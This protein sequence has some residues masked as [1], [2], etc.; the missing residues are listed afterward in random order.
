MTDSKYTYKIHPAIGFARVGDSLDAYYLEPTTVGGLP[1]EVGVDGQ[2]RPVTEF[3]YAGQ[4]KRQAARF[5]VYRYEDG[6][7]PV[8]VS[9]GNGLESVQWTVHV[10]NKKAAWY[11]F[12]E[13]QGNVMLGLDNTYEAQGVPLRN[14]TV[15]L[16]P[17]ATGDVT[18]RYDKDA[19]QELITDPG[20][21][22]LTAPGPWVQLDAAT[23]P[24]DYDYAV[25][26]P[27][28]LTPYQVTTLGAVKMTDR[29]ELLVLGGHGNAGG[30][31][32][33]DINSFAGAPGWYDD[34]SD[35]PVRAEIQTDDGET[36]TLTAWVVT[37]AP[38]LAPELV[39][40]TSLA[41]TFIDVGVRHMG[42]CPA[43]YRPGPRDAEPGRGYD[44]P[45][46]RQRHHDGHERGHSGRLRG[47]ERDR[48]QSDR[49]HG[50]H[51]HRRPVSVSRDRHEHGHD[52]HGHG[53]GADQQHQ[54]HDGQ[55][56]PY[57]W[58][59]DYVA[60]LERDILPIFRAMKE[61]RWV[62][63]VDAM[64]SVATPPF[65][66]SDLSDANRENRR[67]VFRTFRQPQKGQQ[68][69]ELDSQHQVL[70][71]DNGLPL[72][73]LNSGDNSI[74]NNVIEKFMAVTP[75]QYWLLHQWAE[76]MCVSR[77]D[78]PE[79][80]QDWLPWA[81]PLDIA[82]AGNAVGEPMAPGIEV[83]WTM[84]NPDVLTPGDPFRIKHQVAD[85]S[86]W[87][88]DPFRDETLEGDGCQPGDLTKRMAIPWQADFF[89]CSEQD[90]N[91]TTPL[92]N[93]TISQVWR[94][95]LA[96]TFQAYWWPAQ[97]PFNV[98][99]G[100][101]T[102]AE[103]MLD[104]NAYLGTNNLGQVF[105]QNLLYHRGLNS[106]G[107]SVVGWK[108]LGFILNTTTGPLKDT[109]P[110]FVERERNYEA[111][112]SGYQGLTSDGLLYTTQPAT[113]TSAAGVNNNSQNVFP[114]QW[115][116]GN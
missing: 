23:V 46:P 25:F 111:F 59:P 87:G 14:P 47:H 65:D 30:P 89:D 41:D 63:N 104:G 31:P 21:R 85:Y 34:V 62:A 76:G 8:E 105:G 80:G 9:P 90:V 27:P 48:V 49:E 57:G 37:G 101:R 29:G 70:F 75:T 50:R 112:A 102:A 28:D 72:M 44:S 6:K 17:D 60:C 84:R 107:D 51:D 1:T 11:T 73:P 12:Q 45:K 38:K 18:K 55:D 94:I 99:S 68:Q 69:P 79:A 3:K 10:A 91:F 61:Y 97:S 40:I 83:T 77:K 82:T 42:L 114:L 108:Y 35:G 98:Y 26:P 32:G 19:R 22:T 39:N 5:R 56:G 58:Q 20:P 36:I 16:D 116:I 92:A 13:L 81:S 67:H 2:E 93:K 15:G 71:G 66:L 78:D 100:A 33:S 4:V 113:V 110:F 106:F 109:F 103:Q 115:L 96:P 52:R 24:S 64:V 43:L 95:P 86:E 88:L 7:D 54:A 53:R 74:T